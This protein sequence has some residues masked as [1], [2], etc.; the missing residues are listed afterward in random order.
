MPQIFVNM[1]DRALINIGYKLKENSFKMRHAPYSNRQ[2][3]QKLHTTF[4]L[5]KTCKQLV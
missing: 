2:T 1:N 5:T 4:L 3:A